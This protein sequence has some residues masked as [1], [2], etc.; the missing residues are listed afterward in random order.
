MHA[1]VFTIPSDILEDR[2]TERYAGLSVQLQRAADYVLAHPLEIVSRPLRTISTDSDVSPAT[3][4]RLARALGFDNFEAMKEASRASVGQRVGSFSERAELLRTGSALGQS[5]LKRQ[6]Q[7]CVA[8]IAQFLDR[9]DQ[10]KLDQAATLMRKANRVL[11]VGT[12]ASTGITEYISYLAHYFAPNW[13]LAGRMG[14]S[15]GSQLT[16]LGDGD[17][18]FIV[19]MSP[20]SKR[21]VHAAELARAAGCTVVLI[22]DAMSC[23]ALRNATHGFVVP[24]DSPQFFSSYV[25]P[26]V[27]IETLIAMIVAGSEADATAAIQRVEAKNHELGEY[28]TG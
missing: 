22:T 1:E 26:L 8:N 3:Y 28:W 16:T 19:T 17:V 10:E 4:S 20:Y 11:L 7:A 23:P 5:M 21:A 12:L 15:M 24:T 2:V 25:V 18:V 13:S 6:G 9:V 27:L 14:A